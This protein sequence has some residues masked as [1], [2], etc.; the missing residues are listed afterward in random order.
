MTF[1]TAI[2]FL[3]AA[4]GAALGSDAAPRL[5]IDPAAPA[6]GEVFSVRVADLPGNGP[7]EAVLG[8]ARFP[9]W[10][11]AGGWEG[12]GAV[13]RDAAPGVRTLELRA[14][15][16]PGGAGAGRLLAARELAVG[17]RHYPEQRIAVSEALVTLSPEDQARA[18]R[19]AARIRAALAGRSDRRLWEGSF[20]VPAEGPFSSP[21]GVRRIYNDKPRGYHG[22]LDIAAPRGA[23]VLAAAAGRVALAGDFFYT[24]NTVFLDH[25]LGLFTAYFHLDRLAVEEGEALGAGRLLGLVGSTGRSTGPHLHWGVYVSGIRADPVSLL[26]VAGG[27]VGGDGP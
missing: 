24:G 15:P 3:I 19:E 20:R 7:Y 23:P 18:D 16:A 26:R 14:M 2:F 1:C 25:G 27:G 4:A 17:T 11:T 22:G 12:L 9:L 21:F 13:D 8:E 6:P 5:E 10:P